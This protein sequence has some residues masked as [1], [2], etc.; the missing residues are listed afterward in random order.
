MPL[1]LTIVRAAILTPWLGWL[2]WSD[3]TRRRLPNV[4]TLG[5]LL[6]GLACGFAWDGL[7]GFVEAFESA[8]IGFLFLFL[9]FLL[10]GAAA[11]DVK[12]IAA[13]AS[14]FPVREIPAFLV[15]V[16]LAGFFLMV[17]M[18]AVR[19]VSG[20]RLKHWFRC[21]F[22][23]RYDRKAGRAAIPSADDERA[24]VPFGIAIAAGTWFTLALE[25][26]LCG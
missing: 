6:A 14:F 9:P 26:V 15:A 22:D 21:V 16:S 3:A 7:D 5:G 1:A 12:M 11:G 17:S 10:R 25:A 19:G 8:G 20:A 2:C 24:R 4:L 18:L 13:C 23:W